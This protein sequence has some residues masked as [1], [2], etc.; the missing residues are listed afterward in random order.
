MNLRL[1][2]AS[3]DDEAQREFLFRNTKPADTILLYSRTANLCILV[4]LLVLMGAWMRRHFDTL[5]ALVSV[6]ILVVDPNLRAHGRYATLDMQVTFFIVL[7]SFAWNEF[8]DTGRPLLAAL[9]GMV[10]GCAVATKYSAAILVPLLVLLYLVK[11]A[12]TQEDRD[13]PSFFSLKHLRLRLGLASVIMFVVLFGAFGF[14]TGTL[15]NPR[16]SATSES[17]SGKLRKNPQIVGPF[18]TVLV[19]HPQLAAFADTAVDRVPLPMPSLIRGL[20]MVT[21]H[22]ASGHDTYAF[23]QYCGLVVLLSCFGSGQD[24]NGRSIA[25][26]YGRSSD[27]PICVARGHSDSHELPPRRVAGPGLA[28]PHLLRGLHLQQAEHWSASHA[29][30]LSFLLRSC[31]WLLCCLP[32]KNGRHHGFARRSWHALVWWRRKRRRLPRGRRLL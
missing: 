18:R 14:E 15:F 8:L 5:P 16:I 6:L 12:L 23:G 26:L 9:T 2:I 27:S 28:A 30:G 21:H 19:E 22:V 20:Y 13:I 29:S 1:P 3:V 17:L 7:G 10:L 4:L 31:L 25:I 11:W 32:R 24:A